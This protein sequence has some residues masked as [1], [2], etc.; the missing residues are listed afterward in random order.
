[1]PEGKE[2]RFV[3]TLTLASM[4]FTYTLL[5]D[6]GLTGVASVNNSGNVS[7]L[8]TGWAQ[9]QV[10]C[11][12]CTARGIYSQRHDRCCVQPRQFILSPLSVA[13]RN[14]LRHQLFWRRPRYG[15]L[16]G[17]MME[18]A[19]LNSSIITADPSG[20]AFGDLQSTSCYSSGWPTI[21]IRRAVWNLF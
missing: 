12:S 11:S 13:N 6:G 8:M 2:H 14:Q 17:P 3:L 4:A 7:R 19:N 10:S 1:M 16:V 18:E 21:R 9:V 5:P 15:Y 20:T